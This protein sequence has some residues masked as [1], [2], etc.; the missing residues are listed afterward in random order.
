M[1]AEEVRGFDAAVTLSK[2]GGSAVDAGSVLSV[3]GLD[4]KFGDECV[5]MA[6]GDDAEEAIAAVTVLIESAWARAEEAH[7]ETPTGEVGGKKTIPLSLS[8]LNPRFVAGVTAC[9]GIGTGTAVHVGGLSLPASLR[10]SRPASMEAELGVAAGALGAVAA[11]LRAR[12]SA[13]GRPL[14]RDVLMAHAEIA[15]DPALRAA[16]ESEIRAGRTAVQAVVAAGNQFMDRLRAAASAYIRDRVIDVQDICSQLVE[17][18]AG[19]NAETGRIE[20]DQESVV[21][22]DVLTPNQLMR[23][24]QAKLK[25]LVLGSVGATSHTVILARSLGIPTILDA[26]DAQTAIAA[27]DE[28]I[29]DGDNGLALRAAE[30]G[31]RRYYDVVARTERRRRERLEPIVRQPGRTKDGVRL[32]VA[33]NASTPAEA[34]AAAT[35]GGEGVGLLRTELLFLDRAD[36][37]SEEEQFEAYLGVVEAAGGQ[38]VII[39]TLDIGGD[40]PATYMSI[41]EEENPFLGCRGIRLYPKHL[42]LLRAQLRAILRAS[43]RGPVKVMAPMVATVTEAAWF[44]DQVR[45]AQASLKA[46]GIAFDEKIPV[47][48]MIE[49][50]SVSLVIDELVEV[51]DFFSVGTND[52]CQ[53]WMAVDRGNKAVAPLYSAR[54]PSFLRLLAGIVKAARAKGVWIG[55]CGEMA[56]DRL[57]LPLLVG[58]GVNEISVAP[59]EIMNLKAAL[60][61]LESGGCR[62][63]FEKALACRTPEE[64]TELLRSPGSL[65]TSGAGPSV[66]DPHAVVVESDASNKH[67]AICEGVDALFV[68]GRSDQPDEVERAAWA[69]EETYST[70][71]GYGFAIPHCKTT[72]VSAATLAVV[73]LKTPIEWGSNDGLPVDIVLLLAVPANDTGGTHMKVFAKLARKL[74][75][76][77]FRDRLRAANDPAT[78]LKTLEEELQLST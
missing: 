66:L 35:R 5:V 75:H 23:L 28:V 29:V 72:G 24:D 27:G 74:M 68:S 3:V 8:V 21:I 1:L 7:P 2:A 71:L 69:R 38:T 32:E 56:S 45:E 9:R 52:L 15:G 51:V 41:P 53:Y 10:E 47:G 46:D 70:G 20:L 18:L 31:V 14:E 77:S 57:H 44:R 33:A 54:Q 65:S 48:V 62:A 34:R 40:K 30:P 19:S 55:V 76:E 64:V 25:G 59:G 67:E 42:S 6:T 37:P 49:V 63:L 73:K 13:A 4:V 22:A 50:P 12:G 26:R 16:I 58:M 11:E 36:A 43:A 17:R 78:I 61:G 39:R 60:T